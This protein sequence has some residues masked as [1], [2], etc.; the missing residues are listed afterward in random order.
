M[1]GI[2]NGCIRCNAVRIVSSLLCNN[3]EKPV[4]LINYLCSI[5]LL[6]YSF[7]L[8]MFVFN[9]L[10]N[11]LFF[12]YTRYRIEGKYVLHDHLKDDYDKK[13]DEVVIPKCID[14]EDLIA[15]YKNAEKIAQKH[16]INHCVNL[17]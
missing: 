10:P 3:H 9:L 17:L 2:P 11:N 6:W 15:N 5:P 7:L 4:K 12:L 1:E 8:E 16:V 14:I 13:K